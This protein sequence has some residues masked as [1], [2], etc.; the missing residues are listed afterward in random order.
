MGSLYEQ[1]FYNRYFLTN[2]FQKIFK[3][4][5]HS[6]RSHFQRFTWK[7]VENGCFV[8]FE[9]R[10]FNVF[11]PCF[12]FCFVWESVCMPRILLHNGRLRDPGFQFCPPGWVYAK[13]RCWRFYSSPLGWNQAR[14]VCQ[15]LHIRADL[16]SVGNIEENRFIQKLAN[17]QRSRRVKRG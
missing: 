9:M 1:S 5:W 12:F 10:H 4:L 15:N 17:Q 14:R 3:S 11:Y 16:A 13:F 7:N 2:S 8:W 6:I